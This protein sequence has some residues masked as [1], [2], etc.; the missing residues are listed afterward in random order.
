MAKRGRAPL[1]AA[2]AR[3]AHTKQKPKPRF[4]SKAHRQDDERDP[5]AF[6]DIRRV[7]AR[8]PPARTR[9]KG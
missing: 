7:L 3:T 4:V 5:L 8:V 9:S 6:D 1:S 2:A